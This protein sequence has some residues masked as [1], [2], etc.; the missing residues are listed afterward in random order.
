MTRSRRIAVLT[1]DLVDS[2]ALEHTTIETIFH[3][4]RHAAREIGVWQDAP[5]RLAR[6]RGDGWQIC[7]D[8]PELALRSALLF[9]AAIR[10]W[11]KTLQTRVA[12]AIGDTQPGDT[13]DPN[14]ATGPAFVASGRALDALKGDAT[15]VH[16][17]GGALGAATRLADHISRDWTEA[18]ASAVFHALPPGRITRGEIGNTLGKSRQAVDQAL[19]AAGFR[20]LSDA[21]AMIE[22]TTA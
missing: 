15:M 7:L 13:R 20:A 21:L 17:A 22:E 2:T 9:R 10:S 14:A 12:I 4:L 5:I 16:A 19:A 8:R 6:S 3:A 18:Q 1:G 11:G